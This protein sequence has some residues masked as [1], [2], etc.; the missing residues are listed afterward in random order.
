MRSI[1][2]FFNSKF[3]ATSRHLAVDF[4]TSFRIKAFEAY[5]EPKM[6]FFAHGLHMKNFWIQANYNGL[7]WK[8]EMGESHMFVALSDFIGFL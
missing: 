2:F 7:L 4:A 5:N 6:T 1:S 8:G 3:L